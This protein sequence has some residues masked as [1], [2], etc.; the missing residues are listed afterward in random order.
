MMIA[1]KI[2]RTD[3]FFC[4]CFDSLFFAFLAS[5]VHQFVGIVQKEYIIIIA[6]RVALPLV[7]SLMA[8]KL[9]LGLLEMLKAKWW[10]L[11]STEECMYMFFYIKKY[12]MLW[13]VDVS[14]TSGII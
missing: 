9:F 7:L 11:M 2:T 1:N 14:L 4:L 10:T 3:N 12:C 13:V 5:C 8:P 6:L